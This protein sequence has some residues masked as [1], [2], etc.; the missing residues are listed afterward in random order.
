MKENKKI[1]YIWIN[2]FM[3]L[4]DFAYGCVFYIFTNNLSLSIGLTILFYLNNVEKGCTEDYF[5]EEIK[6]L[7]GMIKI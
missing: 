3:C 2:L 4:T 5:K 1:D 7:K 6:R